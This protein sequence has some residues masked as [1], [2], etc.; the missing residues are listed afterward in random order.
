MVD[1]DVSYQSLTIKNLAV[2]AGLILSDAAS[3]D[4]LNV[5]KRSSK[6]VS[7][8]TQ[9]IE[10]VYDFCYSSTSDGGGISIFN[11]IIPFEYNAQDFDENNEIKFESAINL[12]GNM[13]LFFNLMATSTSGP[14]RKFDMIITTFGTPKANLDI[15]VKRVLVDDLGTGTANPFITQSIDDANGNFGVTSNAV[16]RAGKIIAYDFVLLYEN[17]S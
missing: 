17:T 11:N 7:D 15:L 2:S 5:K 3:I 14:L 16:Y 12:S 10:R 1:I 6:P 4:T 8:L 13:F 9:S